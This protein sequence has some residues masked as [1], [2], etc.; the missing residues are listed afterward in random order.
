MV[1]IAGFMV[2]L[3]MVALLASSRA[4]SKAGRP[5]FSPTP[6][7]LTLHVLAR[8]TN[9]PPTWTAFCLSNGTPGKFIYT[10]T[11]VEY[12]TNGVWRSAGS[13]FANTLPDVSWQM[14]PAAIDEIASRTTNKLY[15]ISTSS[16][17]WRI[18]LGCFAV[19]P[20]DTVQ[21]FAE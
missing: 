15:I 11:E 2:A 6:D 20:R 8:N 16:T 13:Y 18:R 12:Y 21:M 10:V 14:Y 5:L 4:R 1:G 19:T 17:P 3:W 7:G 9:D